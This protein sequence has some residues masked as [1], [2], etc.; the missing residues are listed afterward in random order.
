M[1]LSNK[2]YDII[3]WMLTKA[4]APLEFIIEYTKTTD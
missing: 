2:T 1:K 3:K 4:V